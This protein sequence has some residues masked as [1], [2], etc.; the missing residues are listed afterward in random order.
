MDALPPGDAPVLDWGC[1]PGN[2][3]AIMVSHEIDVDATDASPEMAAVAAGLGVDV[4]IEPFDALDPAPRYR[5][6]WANF[7]LLHAPPDV[8][9]DLVAL[10][11]RAL[12]PGG[13]LHLGMKQG[14]GSARD[15]IGRYFSYWQPDDLD[16]MTRAAGLTPFRTRLG[17]GNG[18]DGRIEPFVIHLSRKPA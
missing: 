16:R 1:G 15:P 8:V 6:I 4:R 9:P 14:S 5:G 7:A 12:L 11:G 17:E 10:A 13:V 3:A 18:L 2:S